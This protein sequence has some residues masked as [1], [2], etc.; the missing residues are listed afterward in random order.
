[1]YT[2]PERR[3]SASQPRVVVI[4]DLSQGRPWRATA[5]RDSPLNR[6]DYQA[7]RG[8]RNALTLRQRALLQGLGE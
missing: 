1:M 8:P 2:G 7:A 5:G 3:K 6:A 4:D